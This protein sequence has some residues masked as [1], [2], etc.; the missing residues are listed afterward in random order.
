M[1][2]TRQWN[3]EGTRG[4][5][6]LRG[7][8]WV[9]GLLGAFSAVVVWVCLDDPGAG[10]DA[11]DALKRLAEAEGCESG[12]QTGDTWCETVEVIDR[13]AVSSG[14]SDLE[15]L[16]ANWR[17][18]GSWDDV[19]SG[20]CAGGL[21]GTVDFWVFRGQGRSSSVGLSGLQSSGPAL[22]VVGRCPGQGDTRGRWLLGGEVYSE[23]TH[24]A[25]GT[26]SR[27]TRRVLARS[28]EGNLDSCNEWREHRVD[29]Q[30]VVEAAWRD[31]GVLPELVGSPGVRFMA[32][33]EFNWYQGVLLVDPE[34]PCGRIV[35][36][37]YTQ[38]RVLGESLDWA[39]V[40]WGP[41]LGPLPR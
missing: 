28:S 40:F 23:P 29:H 38:G 39:A 4:A 16:V 31:F 36:A 26:L 21:Q 22:L 27:G 33:R 20:W 1:S 30:A 34:A 2:T 35:A 3:P 12:R 32:D 6:C 13:A 25:A 8:A 7:C 9:G 5:G 18:T 14:P 24:E 15:E 37:E 11:I 10:G 17:P 41:P 19:S